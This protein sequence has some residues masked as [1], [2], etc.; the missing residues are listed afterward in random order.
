MLQSVMRWRFGRR[1]VADSAATDISQ[2]KA[3]DDHYRAYVGP[4]QRFGL[5]ALLQINLLHALGLEE[6]DRVL[7]FG[8]GSLRLGRVLIPFLNPGC[9]FGIDPNGWLMEEGLRHETGKDVE[10]VKRPRF[11]TDARFDCGV[12]GEQF[13]F[14]MAQSVITHSG[15]DNTLAFLKSAAGALKPDGVV[16]LSY[17]PNSKDD[18][19]PQEAWTYPQNVNYPPAWLA[20]KSAGHGL[21]WRDIDWHH[22]GAKWALIAKNETR[23]PP[24]DAP[25]GLN[26]K[27]VER[28]RS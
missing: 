17:L 22:P 24:A 7:D 27:P 6:T 13:D 18:T 21:I 14:I 23:L 5:L 12:F 19:V 25:L 9:Y 20:E 28:W 3:G 8:C 11:S 16:M 2:L 15:A 26:G 4:P 1:A 10:R